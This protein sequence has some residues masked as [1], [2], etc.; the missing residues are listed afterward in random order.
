MQ[1]SFCCDVPQKP[2]DDYCSKLI[3]SDG[4]FVGRIVGSDRKTR[5]ISIS[6]KIVSPR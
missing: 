4:I 6:D 5:V 1:D 3:I 2:L